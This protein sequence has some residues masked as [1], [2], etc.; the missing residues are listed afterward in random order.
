M[1]YISTLFFAAL[2]F[3]FNSAHA[4]QVQCVDIVGTVVVRAVDDEHL[5]IINLEK[6]AHDKVGTVTRMQQGKDCF[7]KTKNPDFYF[8]DP[9]KTTINGIKY[10]KYKATV[11]GLPFDGENIIVS[12][13]GVLNGHTYGYCGTARNG[14]VA[15]EM[16]KPCW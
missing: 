5:P 15:R 10:I 9:S 1:K 6:K 3:N 16:E 14:F 2:I 12:I 13:S 8:T 7:S 4:A 11:K